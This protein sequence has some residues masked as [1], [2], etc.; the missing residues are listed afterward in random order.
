[1]TQLDHWTGS[2]GDA[3]VDR[4]QGGRAEIGARARFLASVLARMGDDLPAS[5]LELGCNI[6]LNLKALYGLCDATLMGIEPNE[7][8]RT[9]LAGSGVLQPDHL[10][11]GALPDTGLPAAQADLVFTCGVLIHVPEE[12]LTATLREMVRLSTRY[13]LMAEYFSPRSE[14]IPYRG[15]ND[16]LFKRDFGGLL[17]DL[18]PELSLVDYGFQ[19]RRVTGLD[20]L[21]WW[22][23]RKP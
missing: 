1:M 7:K 19:W 15:E 12:T 9:A 8:A 13:V 3:Y 14:M 11:G 23:F 10:F 2:F 4:N 17:W 20:D 21:T 5:I 18:H 22:L 6:G 16:L